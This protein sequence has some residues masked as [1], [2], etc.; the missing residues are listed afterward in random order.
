MRAQR[1][2]PNATHRRPFARRLTLLA[3]RDERTSLARRDEHARADGTLPYASLFG[4][5]G[6]A[7]KLG[8]DGGYGMDK[9][10]AAAGGLSAT[11]GLKA[12]LNESSANH[13][14]MIEVRFKH[15]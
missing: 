11:E 4:R 1:C 5:D 6:L 12:T 9:P 8:S 10:W 3:E 14:R 7:G 13:T 15:H 2:R